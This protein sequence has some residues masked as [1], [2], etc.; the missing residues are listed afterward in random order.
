M[1]SVADAGTAARI[2]ARSSFSRLR[3][4]SGAAA[5]YSSTVLARL[6]FFA[7]G[8]LRGFGFFIMGIV[9]IRRQPCQKDCKQ[10]L[11]PIV[12]ACSGRGVDGLRN[13]ELALAGRSIWRTAVGEDADLQCDCRAHAGAG[14]R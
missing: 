5:K 4:G 13:R 8:R 10:T 12:Y 9:S 11:S 3:P 14:A 1:V 2:A 6:G 7:D